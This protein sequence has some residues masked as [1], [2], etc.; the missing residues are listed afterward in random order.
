LSREAYKLAITPNAVCLQASQAAGLHAGLQTLLQ[1]FRQH[2]ASLPCLEINDGPQFPARGFYHD[3][4]RGK[5]PRIETLFALAEKMAHYKLNQLQLYIEHTFAFQRHPD[6]WQGADPLTAEDIASLDEHCARLHIEL[7]P[8]LSTFGHFYTALRSPRKEHLNELDLQASEKPFS[9]HDRGMHYT[10]DCTNP[11]SLELVRELINELRPLFRSNLFNIC[12]DETFDLGK[13]RNAE[14]AKTVGVG[15]LYID[16]LK[17]I[18]QIVREAGSIPMFWGDIVAQ[19]P[20]LV[21]ELPRDVIALDWDYNWDM[22][23]HDRSA[24]FRE[25]GIPFYVCPGVQTWQRWSAHVDRAYSNIVDFAKLGMREGATG[26]LNTDW[27]DS[28]HVGFL[29]TSYHG[30]V[31]G[32]AAS[33]NSDHDVVQPEQFDEAFSRLECG[34][35][36]GETATA[37]RRISRAEGGLWDLWNVLVLWLDAPDDSWLSKRLERFPSDQLKYRL[38]EIE[39]A[40]AALAAAAIY[41]RAQDPLYFREIL[42]GAYGSGLMIRIALA[43]IEETGILNLRSVADEIRRFETEVTAL[44][45]LRNRPSDYF[46]VRETLLQMALRLDRK[47]QKLTQSR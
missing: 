8:S 31:A 38:H 41:S 7:V 9:W 15:R 20:E 19:H 17:K 45:H 13:G 33:W 43:V 14:A 5:V 1:L 12:C 40:H 29:A 34:D 26:M 16:F 11:E 4:T 39:A 3:C 2:G 30:M 10:L 37:L 36:R 23:K 44:W 47:A 27:G 24:L 46:R 28:G 32:A 35:P 42:A 22:S 25:H 21:D 18:M 6:I